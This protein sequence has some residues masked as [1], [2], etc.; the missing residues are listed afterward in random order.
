MIIVDTRSP[1]PPFEQVRAQL[2]RQIHD[3]TLA[4]GTRLPTIR[5]L[6]ADLGL[7]INTVGRAYRELEE[8]GLIETRGRG[9]TYVAAAGRHHLEQV[10]QAARQ[11]AAT[12][13]ALG[14]GLDEARRIVEAALEASLRTRPLWGHTGESSVRSDQT[15]VPD[16]GAAQVPDPGAGGAAPHP[17]S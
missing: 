11:Y 3:G 4:V 6:A 5:R 14:I 13:S 8:A 15:Q 12:A 10:R 2:A 7:A 16:P 1:V 9:G 17:S